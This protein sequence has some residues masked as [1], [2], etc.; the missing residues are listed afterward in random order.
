[1][2]F[3]SRL[4]HKLR[5]VSPAVKTRGDKVQLWF[6]PIF[7][8][9]KDMENRTKKAVYGLQQIQNRSMVRQ[10]LYLPPVPMN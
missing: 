5:G 9:M 8:F 7:K 2:N 4:I 6:L 1:M 3:I 10:A